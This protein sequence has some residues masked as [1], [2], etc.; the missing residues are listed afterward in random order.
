V[1]GLL[2]G[3]VAGALALNLVSALVPGLDAALAGLP[4]IIGLLVGGT[5]VVLLGGLRRR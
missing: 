4:I 2:A 1:L 3:I 5:L